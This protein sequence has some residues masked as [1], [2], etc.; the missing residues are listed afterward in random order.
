MRHL[1]IATLLV[2]SLGSCGKST[3]TGGQPATPP[4][5]PPGAGDKVTLRLFGA[6]WCTDCKHDFPEIRDALAEELAKKDSRIYGE[7]YITTANDANE[8]PNQAHSEAY[9]DFLKLPFAVVNDPWKWQTFKAQ[10]QTDRRLPAAVVMDKDGNVLKV[11]K[12]GKTTFVVPEIVAYV[13]G[14]IK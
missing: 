12:P 2:L 9:R 10:I 6:P 14:L 5:P 3:G 8:A 7:L 13:K 4:A 1:V 11:F